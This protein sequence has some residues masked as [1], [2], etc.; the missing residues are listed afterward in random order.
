MSNIF[1]VF[2]AKLWPND[3]ED[4]GQC[5]KSLYVTHLLMV[6]IINATYNKNLCRTEAVMGRTYKYVQ[7]F[8]SFIA[9]SWPND[10]EIICQVQRLLHRIMSDIL[11]A[12]CGKKLFRI[13]R[14][15]QQTQKYVTNHF[16]SFIAVMSE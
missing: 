1:A 4:I 13:T 11:C 5:Q 16:S 9:K 10:L 14:T 3:P 8:S 12:K 6:V 2:V 7:Y 15:V